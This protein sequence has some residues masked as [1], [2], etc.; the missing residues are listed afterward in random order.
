MKVVDTADVPRVRTSAR[1]QL[2]HF[3][4][5]RDDIDLV[6]LLLTELVTNA[7][8]HGLPPVIAS[9]SYRREM[10]RVEVCDSSDGEPLV[11]HTQP[12]SVGGRGMRL[13]SSLATKWGWSE[14]LS[15]KCV[16]FEVHP[17]EQQGVHAPA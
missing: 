2:R 12:D 5:S 13:V 7:L 16:W 14:M 3:G 8:R 1:E 4:L 15:G 6:S 10:V 17:L 9:I 11:L